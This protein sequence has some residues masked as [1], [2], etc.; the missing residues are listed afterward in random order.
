MTRQGRREGSCPRTLI[1]KG[2]LIGCSYRSLDRSGRVVAREGL[3]DS[4][5]QLVW[6][7]ERVGRPRFVRGRRRGVIGLGADR[8]FPPKVF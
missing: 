4:E 2:D 3:R 5:L 8:N 1:R 7:E 6:R